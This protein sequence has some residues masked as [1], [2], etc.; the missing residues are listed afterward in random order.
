MNRP[1]QR[2]LARLSFSFLLVGGWLGWEAYRAVTRGT[3]SAGDGRLLLMMVGAGVAVLLG[4]QG[5]RVRHR[6]NREE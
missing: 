6:L 5:I 1:A 4:V 3:M 2:W